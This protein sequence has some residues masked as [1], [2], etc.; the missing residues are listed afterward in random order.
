MLS[1]EICWNVCAKTRSGTGALEHL[2][3]DPNLDTTPVSVRSREPIGSR[4]SRLPDNE[5]ILHEARNQDH[6]DDGHNSR[7]TLY[8][9][10]IAIA[11]LA[12]STSR[13]APCRNIHQFRPLDRIAA[14]TCLTVAV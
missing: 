7:I 8:L 12:P 2:Y 6:D 5:E 9:S 1:H 13:F 11:Y 10:S 14:V 4:G 3:Y